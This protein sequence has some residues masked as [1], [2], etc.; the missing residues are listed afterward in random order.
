[1]ALPAVN[2]HGNKPGAREKGKRKFQEG[3]TCGKVVS[4]YLDES[5][6]RLELFLNI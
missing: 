2:L 4:G 1:M 5:V 6:S 3:I